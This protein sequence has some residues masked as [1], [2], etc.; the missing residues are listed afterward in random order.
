MVVSSEMANSEI[1]PPFL[2]FPPLLAS[3]MF[4]ED[5]ADFHF[6]FRMPAAATADHSGKHGQDLS[7]ESSARWE[8]EGSVIL[9]CFLL[10][11]YL[12]S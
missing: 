3:I 2:P 9:S 10:E 12:F 1:E 8:C 11:L 6:C 4:K 7:G 5:T